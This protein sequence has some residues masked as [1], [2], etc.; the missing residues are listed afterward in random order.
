LIATASHTYGSLDARAFTAVF[1]V[2]AHYS[3]GLCVPTDPEHIPAANVFRIS[4]NADT[5][6][7]Q[8]Y[9]WNQNNQHTGAD[10]AVF[11]LDSPATGRPYLRIRRT[12][13]ATASDNTIAV[14]HPDRLGAKLFY[15]AKVVD[16]IQDV[17]VPSGFP[18]PA[19]DQAYFSEGSSGGP[20]YNL[21]RQYV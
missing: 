10:Y 1:G 15:G 3:N 2:A 5:V 18:A 8:A 17:G 9:Y 19:V 12:G 11:R 14:G 7:A 20:T 16:F 21:D 6:N 4:S 13:Q